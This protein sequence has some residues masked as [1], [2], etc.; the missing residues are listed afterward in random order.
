MAVP[1]LE[2]KANTGAASFT[3]SV[4]VAL[5]DDVELEAVIV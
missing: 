1:A 4:Y 2:D 3:V 5:D